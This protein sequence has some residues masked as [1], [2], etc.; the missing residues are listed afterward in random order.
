MIQIIYCGRSLRLNKSRAFTQS[1]LA[2]TRT[3]QI[4]LRYRSV[5]SVGSFSTLGI[6]L[7]VVEM[8]LC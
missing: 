4:K 7:N 1:A 3:E 6:H 8:L 2:V 5:A